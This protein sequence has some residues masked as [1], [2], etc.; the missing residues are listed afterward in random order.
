MSGITLEEF[1]TLSFFHALYDRPGVPR[2]CLWCGGDGRSP[3]GDV[4]NAEDWPHSGPCPDCEGSGV[5]YETEPLVFHNF[6]TQL[7]MWVC[8]LS[9]YATP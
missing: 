3:A 7:D 4:Y 5:Q 6:G 9:W 1:E 2:Y 8:P